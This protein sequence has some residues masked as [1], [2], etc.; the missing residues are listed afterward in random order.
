MPWVIKQFVGGAQVQPGEQIKSIAGESHRLVSFESDGEGSGHIV[1]IPEGRRGA[2]NEER[3]RP[4]YFRL[5]VE[6]GAPW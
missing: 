1:S 5:V 4:H 2:R 6:G 3:H